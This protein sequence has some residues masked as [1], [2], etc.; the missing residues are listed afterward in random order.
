MN[1]DHPSA[2][3]YLAWA[4]VCLVWGTTYLAIRIALETIP[5][6]LIGGLRFTFAGALLLLVL[7]LKGESLPAPRRWTGLAQLTSQASTRALS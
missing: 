4:V 5:P 2:R 1:P 7:G 6:A 3:P